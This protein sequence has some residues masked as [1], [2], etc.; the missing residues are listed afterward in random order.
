MTDVPLPLPPRV[1]RSEAM[2]LFEQMRAVPPDAAITLDASAVEE[3][4]CAAVSLILSANE[5]RTGG[6][7]VLGAGEPFTSAFTDLG[8]FSDM[9]KLEFVL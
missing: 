3:M 8:C 2:T 7:K 9:M 1:R 6:V 5:G 4:S